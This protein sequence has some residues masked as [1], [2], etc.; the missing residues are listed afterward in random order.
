MRDFNDTMLDI[1]ERHKGK[2]KYLFNI[3]EEADSE[4]EKLRKIKA[5]AKQISEQ[6]K[7]L[8]KLL[9]LDGKLSFQWAR[10]TTGYHLASSGMAM[11]A[12]QEMYGHTSQ[13]TTEGYVKSVF[14]DKEEEI[15]DILE[16]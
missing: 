5:K 7:N 11:K 8:A 16:L 15:D 4:K 13:R 3:I 14:N 12:I 10:H 6:A 9:G 1:I 2:G